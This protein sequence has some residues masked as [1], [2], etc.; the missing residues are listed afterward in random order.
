MRV[1]VAALA[2]LLLLAQWSLWLG[3]GGWLRVRELQ[4]QV[5]Q[6][7]ASNA[8]VAAGNEAL[9]TELQSLADGREAVEERA[10]YDL[11]MMRADETFFQ[12]LPA[13][14]PATVSPR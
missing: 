9:A 6:Q 11:H 4:R 5:A 14:G 7:R 2:A 3:H 1:I 8:L 12:F 10:R 13:P